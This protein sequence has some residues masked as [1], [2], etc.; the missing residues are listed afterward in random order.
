[1]KIDKRLNIVLEVE[2]QGEPSVFVHSMPIT[3]A[4]YDQHTLILA[5]TVS[6]MYQKGIGAGI[7]AR[8]A[9]NMMRRLAKDEDA[10]AGPAVEAM[11]KEVE[12]LLTFLQFL[13]QNSE[14]K[15]IR[16]ISKSLFSILSQEK[17]KS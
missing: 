9:L 17:Y 1:M 5:Q 11:Q 2:R 13:S 7:C 16:R 10:A 6:F 12:Q 3:K 14:S 15:D 4:T 8:I